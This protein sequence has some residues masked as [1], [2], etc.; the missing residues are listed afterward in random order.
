M[1]AVNPDEKWHYHDILILYTIRKE[2]TMEMPTP[3]TFT[4]KQPWKEPE[5]DTI[6]H[7][8]IQTSSNM[9]K[10]VTLVSEEKEQDPQDTTQA[11]L[12]ELIYGRTAILPVK[13]EINTYLAK[14]I[15][16]EN[17]Q[18]TLLRRTYNLMET[19]ENK[20]RRAADNIQKSQEKQKKRHNS[21]LLN[22]PVEFKIGDKVLLYH[23]KAEK[24]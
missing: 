11:T 17:F 19:L 8:C 12:F 14:P 7:Q 10:I 23:T 21:Q 6:G 15:T 16:E 13:R 1:T 5:K 22:K 9:F 4:K 20:Q 18:K 2:K 24:Q 3:D